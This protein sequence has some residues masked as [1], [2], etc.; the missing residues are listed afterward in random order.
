MV[1]RR[2]TSL[3][4]VFAASIVAAVA[5]CAPTAFAAKPAVKKCAP[6]ATGGHVYYVSTTHS[7]CTLADKSVA[8]LAAKR[9]AARSSNVPLSNGPKGFVCQAGTKPADA[10]MPDIAANVQVAGNCAKGIGL[11]PSPYFNWVV[12]SKY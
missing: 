7:T 5:L 9:L 11:G 1:R 10:D 4:V 2:L 12:K 8:A 6:V 3:V